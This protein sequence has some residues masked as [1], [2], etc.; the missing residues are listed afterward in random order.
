MKKKSKK[1]KVKNQK[2]NIENKEWKKKS[3]KIYFRNWDR[4][5]TR[6]KKLKIKKQIE[7]QEQIIK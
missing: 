2:Q 3:N 7:K 5:W 1:W 4:I 6:Y